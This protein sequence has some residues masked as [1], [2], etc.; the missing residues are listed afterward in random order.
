MHE[1]A[2]L[3]GLESFNGAVLV[4]ES[5]QVSHDWVGFSGLRDGRYIT[6]LDRLEMIRLV[7]QLWG[8][9][10]GDLFRR[11]IFEGA[12]PVLLL[13]GSGAWA[14]AAPIRPFDGEVLP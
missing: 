1:Q 14:A 3:A 12:T 6:L 10:A 13:T 8:F 5:P 9:C 4:I 2:N 11:M 7:D